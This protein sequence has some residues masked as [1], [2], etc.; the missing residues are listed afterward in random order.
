MAD[1]LCVYNSNWSQC[2]HKAHLW[3]SSNSS[4]KP[5]H[6]TKKLANAYSEDYKSRPPIILNTF[7]SDSVIPEPCSPLRAFHHLQ[8]TKRER[9][10]PQLWKRWEEPCTPQTFWTEQRSPPTSD[11]TPEKPKPSQIEQYQPQTNIQVQIY[12][13]SNHNTPWITP[14]GGSFTICTNYCNLD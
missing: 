6:A 1:G 2:K 13:K 11:K 3:L 7:T 10:R 9:E 12:L 14:L 8:P 5:P 4:L